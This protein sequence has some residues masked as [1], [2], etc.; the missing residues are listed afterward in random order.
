M[1][2]K[3]YEGWSDPV[4]WVMILCVVSYQWR[5]SNLRL[6]PIFPSNC[7]KDLGL[8]EADASHWLQRTLRSPDSTIVLSVPYT[9][10]WCSERSYRQR[11]F[12]VN[13]ERFKKALSC[14][15]PATTEKISGQA[16]RC[17]MDN[18]HRTKM[19]STVPDEIGVYTLIALAACKQ[20]YVFQEDGHRTII[21]TEKMCESPMAIAGEVDYTPRRGGPVGHSDG[22]VSEMDRDAK[23]TERPLDEEEMNKFTTPAAFYRA[24]PYTNGRLR[25]NTRNGC[26]SAASRQASRKAAMARIKR[27]AKATRR[28][29]FWYEYLAVRVA[30]EAL[31]LPY[32]FAL[33]KSWGEKVVEAAMGA[34]GQFA[35]IRWCFAV[36]TNEVMAAL[37]ESR[38]IASC[39][40]NDTARIAS[41]CAHVENC[42]ISLFSH[43]MKKNQTPQEFAAVMKKRLATHPYAFSTDY[44]SFD[45]TLGRPFRVA[46]AKLIVMVA[47][48]LNLSDTGRYIAADMLEE[49][50]T[51]NSTF[52]TLE[53][54]ASRRSGERMTS[55]GN[56]LANL[57]ITLACLEEISPDLPHALLSPE[58]DTMLG[59]FEGDDRVLMMKEEWDTAGFLAA[60][61][62]HGVIIE[63]AKMPH[64]TAEFCG[65]WYSSED[66]CAIPTRALNKLP[67]QMTRCEQKDQRD[68]VLSSLLAYVRDSG[69]GRVPLINTLYYQA[70]LPW[71]GERPVKVHEVEYG[72]VLVK[73]AQPSVAHDDY[74]D[75][76]LKAMQYPVTEDSP[77]FPVIA[78]ALGMPA[79]LLA[80]R[81]VGTSAS[82]V[83]DY[84]Y[85]ITEVSDEGSFYH[86]LH[87]P[88]GEFAATPTVGREKHDPGQRTPCQA[89]SMLGPQK[90][91]V[92]SE[93]PAVGAPS[94]ESR[95][96]ALVAPK[97]D[98]SQPNQPGPSNSGGVSPGSVEVHV[99]RDVNAR[100]WKDDIYQISFHPSHGLSVP[101][102]HAHLAKVLKGKLAQLPV[103]EGLHMYYP[104][105]SP[106]AEKFEFSLGRS[107]LAWLGGAFC[108]VWKHYPILDWQPPAGHTYPPHVTLFHTSS[109]ACPPA[110][111]GYDAWED[112]K[113]TAETDRSYGSV[114][115]RN[116]TT[117]PSTNPDR[118][119]VGRE[120]QRPK[121]GW[122]PVK[123]S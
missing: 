54:P 123:R 97:E 45:S 33:P 21:A 7:M 103:Q 68:V 82:E 96:G 5:K 44:G 94:D 117:P 31:L 122:L 10:W 60:H 81:S 111:R 92:V 90:Q 43:L 35:P 52:G 47:D 85:G 1:I 79:E 98:E 80:E 78:K 49:K 120:S 32:V 87:C 112:D 74:L 63:D 17:V 3:I 62:V 42:V 115:D 8:L 55:I 23:Y 57:A 65:C 104:A 6:L 53:Y 18:I 50:Y 69:A 100:D 26:A 38:C 4:V 99:V 76:F 84:Q 9:S 101:A 12:R 11:K 108:L 56:F 95:P 48:A 64:G 86:C 116:L 106:D 88:P 39:Q 51:L 73:K 66:S 105:R 37:K 15:I 13:A 30:A 110:F 24:P 27:T 93:I 19:F 36:K 121:K 25:A 114:S 29:E 22:P 14:A 58:S 70:M 59:A 34:L 71:L 83:Q 20:P 67:Y 46:E 61:E 109:V 2:R 89:R 16:S 119:A 77:L 102:I 40:P 28:M 118:L 91:G 113:A 75:E 41:V 107:K 72:K